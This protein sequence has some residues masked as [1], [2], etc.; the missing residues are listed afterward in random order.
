MG[1]HAALF[2]QTKDDQLACALPYIAIGLKRNER[3]VYIAVDN[4]VSEI[5]RGLERIGVNVL[6][7]QGKDALRI[8]TKNDTY[9]RHGL[10]EP[11]KMIQDFHAEVKRVIEDGFE[12]LRAS[13][14][15]SWAL[16]LPSAMAR[17]IEYEEK[18]HAR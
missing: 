10:F 15:M 5:A 2:Y 9:L 16:D 8:V 6:E 14:E 17:V 4:S 7:D 11:D 1:D 12:G 18:L 13:G 3:C